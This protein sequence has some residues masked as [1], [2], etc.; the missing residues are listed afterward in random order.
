[1]VQHIAPHRF[2]L[3]GSI[4]TRGS[5]THNDDLNAKTRVQ[6]AQLLQHF[7]LLEGARRQVR[8]A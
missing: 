4:N 2:H 3:L 8:E 1:M 5:S 6:N 7:H